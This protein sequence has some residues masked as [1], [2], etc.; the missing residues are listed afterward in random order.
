MNMYESPGTP[1]E[2]QR[3]AS[4]RNYNKKFSSSD[5]VDP[6]PPKSLFDGLYE[7]DEND[8][9]FYNIFDG[10]KLPANLK[11][12]NFSSNN[13]IMQKNVASISQEDDSDVL[14]QTIVLNNVVE[15]KSSE[16]QQ[17]PVGKSKSSGFDALA[18]HMARL[19]A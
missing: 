15:T 5:F 18:F 16:I 1:H 7:M 8:K 4:A 19:S 11:P 13:E 17:L 9:E 10:T 6:T 3:Y 12:S 14:I 2:V